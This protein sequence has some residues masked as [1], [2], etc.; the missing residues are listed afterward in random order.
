[1][2]GQGMAGNAGRR[3]SACATAG[4]ASEAKRLP[5]FFSAEQRSRRS[6]MKA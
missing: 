3:Q 5:D 4:C 1:M 2:A 6:G